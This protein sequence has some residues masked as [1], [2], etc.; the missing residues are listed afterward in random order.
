MPEWPH[1]YIVRERVDEALV[2]WMCRLAHR[3]R[4]VRVCCGDWSR[5]MGKAVRTAAAPCAV[6]LDPPYS[7]EA[8]RDMGIYSQDCGNVAHEV[9]DWCVE[10]GPD[11]NLRIALCGYEG[12]G[13]APLEKQG[14]TVEAW[15]ASGGYGRLHGTENGKSLENR[16]RERIW[17]S[18]GC[19]PA[20]GDAQGQLFAPQG[21]SQ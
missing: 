3:L 16:H 10:H 21:V 5:I 14:W 13:H 15:K 19:L 8:D 9:F 12:E 1:E 6:F 7:A 17:F 4:Y 11:P 18:P 2:G 20:E